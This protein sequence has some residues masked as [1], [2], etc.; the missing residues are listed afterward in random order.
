MPR[1]SRRTIYK[2]RGRPSK[3]DDFVVTVTNTP[4]ALEGEK[5]TFG[6]QEPDYWYIDAKGLP[7]CKSC[8]LVDDRGATKGQKPVL[9]S[10]PWTPSIL[11]KK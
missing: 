2:G 6:P 5:H 10:K 3:T 8:G 7:V 11:S 1:M 4:A 9:L